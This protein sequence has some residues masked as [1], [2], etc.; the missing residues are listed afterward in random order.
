MRIRVLSAR[1]GLLWIRDGWRLFGKHPLSLAG[2]MAAGV[3]MVWL[4]STI[5]WVGR[6]VGAVVAPIVSLGFIASCRAA[7]AGRMPSIT[8]YAD[9]LRDSQTRRQLL[10]LGAV[11]AT[12]LLMLFAILQLTGMDDAIKVVSGPNQEPMVETNPG[13]LAAHLALSTPLLMAMWLAPPLVGWL[14]LPALKAMFYSFFACWRNR[15]PLLTFIAGALG[16]ASMATVLLAV[17]VD[18]LVSDRATGALLMTPILL[19]LLAVIQGGI[20]RMY[21]QV[22]DAAPEVSPAA[23]TS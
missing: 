2:S 8:L 23:S 17:I 11:N 15:W 19:A 9:G 18:L 22:V 3:L 10:L 12:I 5:P 4:P 16:V 14:R 6:A 21:T 20:F 13:L 1:S 7:D